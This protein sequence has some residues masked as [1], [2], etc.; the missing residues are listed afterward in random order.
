VSSSTARAL[1]RIAGPHL[2]TLAGCLLALALVYANALPAGFHFDDQQILLRPNLHLQR[3]TLEGLR[4]ALVFTPGS[5]RLYRPV[6]GLTLALDFYFHGLDPA[7]YRLTNIGIH[8]CCVAALYL[9]LHQLFRLPGARPRWVAEHRTPIAAVAAALFALHPLQTNVVTYIIQRMTGLAALFV[10]VS[11]IGFLV[12]RGAVTEGAACRW[13]RLW[14]GAC[15]CLP[16]GVL[17][18][19][20]KENAAILPLLIL[21]IDWLMFYPSLGP[22][23]RQR[24]RRI[25]LVVGAAIVAIGT[26]FGYDLMRS[27]LAG[28][29]QR[30]FTWDQRLLTECR[31][32]LDYLRLLMLPTP[33]ALNFHH[34]VTLSTGVFAPP[35]TLAAL[36]TIITLIALA[37]WVLPCRANL[38]AL[39][40]VW[41][42]GNLAIESTIIPL[43]L[44]YEHRVY[45]PGVAFF[46]SLGSLLV[47]LR[48]RLLGPVAGTLLIATLLLLYGHGTVLRNLVFLDP[49]SFWSDVAAKSTG[50]ARAAASLGK[51]LLNRNQVEAARRELERALRLDPD[52]LEALINLGGLHIATGQ[53][54][55]GLELLHQAQSRH[56]DRIHGYVALGAA[57]L[58]SGNPLEAERW[59]GTAVK[60]LSFYIPAI[61]GLGRAKMLLGKPEEASAVFRHGLELDPANEPL[62]VGL[63]E[64]LLRSQRFSEARTVLERYLSDNPGALTA[65]RLLLRAV[66]VRPPMQATEIAE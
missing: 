47:W 6:S 57:Y 8:A 65:R 15:V 40:I 4:E 56:P 31:V 1:T 39:A 46:A 26:L 36:L 59:Y 5:H 33:G 62:A 21:A 54:R 30:P 42:F 12:F 53:V 9:F 35:S 18:V 32:V 43:E 44:M 63:A 7:G 37:L 2:L 11:L 10:L 20:S 16:A 64:S 48:Q 49:L 14:G 3:L 52:S 45:L 61:A 25:Y 41:Y 17:A 22:S 50:D 27:L 24:S 29:A 28:Y 23:G 58:A 66:P 34:A 51:E 60:K 38:M 55:H 19:M 13:R